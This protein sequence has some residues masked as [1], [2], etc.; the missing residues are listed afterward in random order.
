M[1]GWKVTQWWQW[2]IIGSILP[3]SVLNFIYQKRELFIL[4]A[5][6]PQNTN[7]NNNWWKKNQIKFKIAQVSGVIDTRES[8]KN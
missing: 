1:E 4:I 7:N 2:L 3:A 6:F 8:L 5:T